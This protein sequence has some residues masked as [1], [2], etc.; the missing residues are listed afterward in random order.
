MDETVLRLLVLPAMDTAG[1]ACGGKAD[2]G[3]GEGLCDG[4]GFITRKRCCE[5]AEMTRGGECATAE[6]S[7]LCG[8]VT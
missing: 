8:A 4:L 6:D 5:E 2:G 1:D 3:G 7:M